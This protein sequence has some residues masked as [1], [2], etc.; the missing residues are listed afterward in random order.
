MLK[1]RLKLLMLFI[2]LPTI[3]V[4]AQSLEDMLDDELGE[5]EIINYTTSTFKTTRVVNAQSTKAPAKKNLIFIISHR[6]GKLNQGPVDFFGIDNAQIRMGFEYGIT[7]RLTAGIGRSVYNKNFDAYGRYKLLRQSSG[8]KT[9][10]ITLSLMSSVNYGAYKWNY[11]DREDEF[12]NRMSYVSQ[13]L[14]SRKFNSSFSMQLMPTYIHRNM[15][16]TKTDENDVMAIGAAGRVKITN[17]LAL[18][19]EYHYVLP[20]TTADKFVNSLSTGV[21]I[22]T[23]GHIFQLFLTNS[24]GIYEAAYIPA[25]SGEWLNGDIHFGFNISRTFDLKRH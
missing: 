20:G 22:E 10:P 8:K 14:I 4:Q 13:V 24:T 6:F 7:D 11:E 21:D 25:T 15:V 1:Q 17:R 23:G 19:G 9:M 5:E 12:V 18:T 3:F 2:F 16:A